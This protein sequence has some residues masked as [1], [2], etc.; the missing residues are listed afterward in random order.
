MSISDLLKAALTPAAAHCCRGHT[1]ALLGSARLGTHTSAIDVPAIPDSA[2]NPAEVSHQPPQGGGRLIPPAE[3]QRRVVP[4]KLGP[5]PRSQM[6]PPRE[7]SPAARCSRDGRVGLGSP[8][9][10][11]TRSGY[12]FPPV[13]T[14][15]SSSS[16]SL[17]SR[18]PRRVAC[19]RQRPPPCGAAASPAEAAPS[20]SSP[21]L[22]GGPL[23]RSQMLLQQPRSRAAHSYDGRTCSATALCAGYGYRPPAACPGLPAA[24]PRRAHWA[25]PTRVLTAA[26]Y[27]CPLSR[28]GRPAARCG[29]C[30][31][32]ACRPLPTQ[33]RGQA[34]RPADAPSHQGRPPPS[35]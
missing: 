6:F 12:G 17:V 20:G 7:P 18:S 35:R 8:E 10:P 23:L 4:H 21:V 26:A 34:T 33:C 28:A 25:A 16:N 1:C 9:L 11:V 5:R 24:A 30:D 19:L 3:N 27:K 22:R 32:L 29:P 13:Q 31:G 2:L 14:V 15:R